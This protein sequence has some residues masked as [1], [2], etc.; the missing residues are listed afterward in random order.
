M[1]LPDPFGPARMRYRS[2]T[3]ASRKR[4][5]LLLTD[6]LSSAMRARREADVSVHSRGKSRSPTY[7]VEMRSWFCYDIAV[8]DKVL[9]VDTDDRAHHLS[10]RAGGIISAVIRLS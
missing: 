6:D 3:V 1:L 9:A 10:R 5:L 2:G 7:H 4:V 8:G